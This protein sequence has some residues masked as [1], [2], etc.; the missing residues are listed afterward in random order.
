MARE[1]GDPDFARRCRAIADRGA[2]SMMTLYNGEYF[3]QVEDPAHRDAIGTGPGC[4]IDQVFGQTWAHWVGLGHLFDR[5]AQLSALRALWRYNFVPDVGPFRQQFRKGRWYATAGDAGLL[6]CTWP[7]GGQDPHARDHWQYMYFN[8]CM[9]GFEWQAAAH[10]IWEG[11]DQP[12]ILEH[13]LAIARAIHDRY[14]AA[15]RNP[16]NEVE[17]S[18]HYAR[19]M[20]S[21]GAYQAAC[22]WEYHGP[23]GHLAFAPRLSPDDFRAAFTAAEGWGSFAQSR[24]DRG[25]S[26][27]IRLDH[28][29]LRLRSLG[30]KPRAAAAV[31]SVRLEVDGKP[32]AAAFDRRDDRI[33]VRP[34]S[35][36][37]LEAGQVLKVALE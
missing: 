21:F 19:A 28:G 37:R 36:V 6:M 18:D 33:T 10:M 1:M 30:L 15:L 25:M 13:G 34:A 16:Y 2:R 26:A 9:S 5:A 14:A 31:R 29:T 8:E 27:T 12:D 35:P 4:H 11:Y 20:A 7:K 23:Q 32:L 22:G 17:C 3:I 24:T